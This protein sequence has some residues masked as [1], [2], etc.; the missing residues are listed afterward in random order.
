MKEPAKIA[1]AVFLN[2]LSRAPSKKE[3]AMVKSFLEKQKN[4]DRAL[5]DLV[6]ALLSSTEFYVNH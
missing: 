2:V 1:D 6:W 4:R 3:Q 5:G